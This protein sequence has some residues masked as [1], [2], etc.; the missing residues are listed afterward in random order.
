MTDDTGERLA[1]LEERTKNI[2]GWLKKVDEHQ[3]EILEAFAQAKG[4]WRT[5]VL[6]AGCAGA[7]G[8]ITAKVAPLLGLMK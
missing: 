7:V 3:S 4:G 1:R 8:A 2:E 5:V 6:I